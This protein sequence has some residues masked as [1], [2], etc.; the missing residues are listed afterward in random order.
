MSLLS[1]VP[2]STLSHAPFPHLI[3]ENALDEALCAE[4]TR[5][6]PPL[7]SF[8]RGRDLPE[9]KKIVRRNTDLLADAALAPV[10]RMFLEEHLQPV[11]LQEW[12]RLLGQEMLMEHPEF[13]ARFGHPEEMTV[14]RRSMPGSEACGITLDAALVAH[15]PVLTVPRAERG[16]HLKEPNKPFLGFLFL[17]PEDDVAEGAELEIYEALA[18]SITCGARN[19]V[20]P[21]SVRVVKRV[22][23]R[24][25]T[26]F[27]MLNTTRSITTHA[28]RGLGPH[29]IQYFHCLAELPT[30]LFPLPHAPP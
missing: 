9:N 3:V 27:L 28:V 8:V 6:F 24:T 17:R 26:L 5:T 10:W 12:L 2:F 15:T 22:P 4:L 23:Y 19:E 14:G 13:T 25:N 1:Q 29:P 18:P 16:P 21:E 30:P 11:L 20:T 7:E